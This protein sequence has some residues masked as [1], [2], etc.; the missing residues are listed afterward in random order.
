M[1]TFAERIAAR[2]G[3]RCEYC[4]M[5][6]GLTLTPFTLDHDR[7]RKHG[8]GDGEENRAFA[9]FHC[10]AYKGPNVA[11]YDPQTDELTPLFSPRTQAWNEHFFWNGP[12][13]EGH[14]DIGRT[15][16]DV[17]RINLPDRVEQRELLASAGEPIYA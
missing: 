3:G 7:P 17:L 4:R 2:A 14:T 6:E 1:A 8:G 15:T 13:L 5:P 12:Y 11:G 16:V 10:N 9:C